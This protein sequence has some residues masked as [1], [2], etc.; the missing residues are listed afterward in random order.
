MEERNPSVPLLAS[1]S[2]FYLEVADGRIAAIGDTVYTEEGTALVVEGFQL[3]EC[4][5]R[6]RCDCGDHSVMLYR[7]DELLMTEPAGN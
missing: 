6:V 3:E 5:W 7:Q 2:D 4:G 1:F